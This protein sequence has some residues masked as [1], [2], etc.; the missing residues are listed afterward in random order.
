MGRDSAFHATR[1]QG[2][3]GLPDVASI[4]CGP[5]PRQA[6]LTRM[7]SAALPTGAPVAY[8]ESDGQPMAETDLHRDEMMDLING[9]KDRY[10]DDPTAYVAGNL[11]VYIVEGDPSAV[12]APDVMVVFGVEKR[13]RRTY[14]L[15]EEKR[16]PDIVF[17]VSS[18]KTWVEDRG[19]KRDICKEIGVREYVLYDPEADYLVPPLQLLRR[20]D[21]SYRPA[22]PAAD[23]SLVS[24]VLGLR[25]SLGPDG[26]IVLVDTDTG[27]PVLR[28]A[29]VRAA[30][31]TAEQRVITAEQRVSTAEQHTTTAEQDLRRE[32]E[33]RERLEA[34]LAR[35]REQLSKS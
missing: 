34:E 19:N 11:F 1:D 20:V 12:F 25:M 10:R 4:G 18:R 24:D 8:P 9:L 30:H 14:K 35:L 13:Q 17:E 29:V 23:G 3:R 27:E 33:E 5:R 22:E 31:R 28:D 2:Q 16:P 15:W 6:T 32:R 7:S 21:G 26:R